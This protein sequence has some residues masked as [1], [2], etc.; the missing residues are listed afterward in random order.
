MDGVCSALR[1]ISAC[2]TPPVW[3]REGGG[4]QCTYD[5][6]LGFTIYKETVSRLSPFVFFFMNQ[7]CIVNPSKC[8]KYVVEVECFRTE[9]KLGVYNQNTKT[10]RISTHC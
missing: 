2:I 9:K 5:L 8:S 3:G 1:R 6:D 7:K 10:A 4:I